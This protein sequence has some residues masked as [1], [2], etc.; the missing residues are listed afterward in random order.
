MISPR[1]IDI[2]YVMRTPTFESSV[3]FE[4]LFKGLDGFVGAP[5]YSTERDLGAW[6]Q[7]N[8]HRLRLRYLAVV[9]IY[10]YSVQNI[11]SVKVL[12]RF[13]DFYH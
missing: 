13:K 8:L 3:H 12:S 1:V 6:N 10:S 2:L 5:R 7:W 9:G 4:E 11:L